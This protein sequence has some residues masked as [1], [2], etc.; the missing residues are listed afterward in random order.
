[1]R[2]KRGDKRDENRM[3]KKLTLGVSALALVGLTAPA[4]AESDTIT[5]SVTVGTIVDLTVTDATAALSSSITT[6]TDATADGASEVGAFKVQ[7]NDSYSLSI[8]PTS[9]WTPTNIDSALGTLVKF[10]G[11]TDTTQYMGG[12]LFITSG[13]TTTD[14]TSSGTGAGTVGIGSNSAGTKSW[15]LGA[16]FQPQYA[17][18]DD[19]DSGAGTD[20]FIAPAQDYTTTATVTV[21]ASS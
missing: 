21:T 1:M 17:G 18:D 14:W 9:T 7:A 16:I 2:L 11:V 10:T 19:T 12:E 15:T 13:G 3:F 8:A 20:G 6:A 4:L 5:V